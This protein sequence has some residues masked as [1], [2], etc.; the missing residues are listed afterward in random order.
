MTVT[1]RR[2]ID[3]PGFSHGKLPIP[4]ASRIG[5]FIAS[6]NI[7]GYDFKAGAHPDDAEAQVSL[8]FA[9]MQSIVEAAGAALGD[10]LKV[11]VYIRDDSVRAALDSC[12]IQLFPDPASRPARQAIATPQMP[13]NRL[14]ACDILAVVPDGHAA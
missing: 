4:A 5:P 9:H 12:W 8:M 13:L 7:F 11:T 10:I 1:R 14:V 3:A 2:S 6:G